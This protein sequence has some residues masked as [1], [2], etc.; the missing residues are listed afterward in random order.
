MY[1]KRLSG[2][3][4]PTITPMNE[5][6]SI[7]EKSLANFTEYLIEAGVD[8]LYPNGTNGESLL[9]TKEERQKVA[10]VMVKVNAHRIPVFIQCGS[11]Q[12]RLALMVWVL[13]LLPSSQ[14]TRMLC[15]NITMK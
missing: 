2:V 14:W 1:E 10:E 4:I 11:L 7:D 13:C 15:L 5:D 6:G 3:V 8:C 12:L 9:L